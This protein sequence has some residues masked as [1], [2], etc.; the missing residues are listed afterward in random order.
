M[1][2]ADKQSGLL[3]QFGQAFERHIRVVPDGLI[4]LAVSGGGDS[5]AMMNMAARII[6]PTRLRVVS[7]NHGLRA[8]AV[9]ELAQVG[10]QASRLGIPHVVLDWTWD[11]TGN[12]QAA[13]RDGRWQLMRDWAVET[14]VGALFLGHTED[15]QIETLLL[16]LARG[17][18]VD[19]LTAM[20][21][22]DRR[23]GMSIL[24]PLLG[25]SRD[26]LREW[27][28]SQ[29]IQ[30]S[31][32]PSND[33]VRFDRVRARQMYAQLETLGL[34]RKRFL[35][36]ADH[37]RAAQRSLQ[38]AAHEFAQTYVTQD[39]GDL[40]FSPEALDL[41]AEDVPRRV[42]AEAFSWMAT[43]TY[44][45][46]FENMLARVEQVR[47]GE[48]VTLGGCIMLPLSDGGMRLVR[49]ASATASSLA[50]CD[51][52]WDKR[53]R[54]KG[55]MRD[56]LRFQALGDGLNACKDWRQTGVFRLS[57]LASPSVW[58]QDT[59][60]AAP[61][62]GLSNGWTAQIV[63]DFHSRAFGIED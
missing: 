39:L 21:A 45:P 33:D 19:G 48:Q 34:T 22:L 28:V 35:Q 6:D 61:L 59:L 4:G 18:G 8:E 11:R 46:R 31:D 30:W 29:A 58:H 3:D 41:Q 32:D 51:E 42:M 60:I 52:L 10:A 14:G 43:K 24:R 20:S 40:V 56:N 1:P 5:V 13:A 17:S 53:W 57:L 62:A 25:M 15:D 9:A 50:A 49:E 63:A 44:R 26:A 38:Q 47:N 2:V 54:I 55:P 7:V 27:L 36:T 16:R 23:D 37:M 12:L